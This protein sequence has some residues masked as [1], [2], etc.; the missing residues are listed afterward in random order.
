M[1]KN[2]VQLELRTPLDVK[3]YIKAKYGSVRNFCNQ[4]KLK[5]SI[6]LTVLQRKTFKHKNI[7]KICS[8]L[9]IDINEIDEWKDV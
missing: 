9:D 4:E 3:N 1:F 8:I 6:Y 2:K 7:K 5:Y